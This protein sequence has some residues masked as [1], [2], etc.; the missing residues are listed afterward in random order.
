MTAFEVLPDLRA[1]IIETSDPRALTSIPSAFELTPGFVGM[2]H[3]ID[4]VIRLGMMGIQVP[5]PIEHYYDWPRDRVLYP[6][7]FDHQKVTAGF[8]T[9]NPRCY[10]LNGIGTMKTVTA[11]WAADY[12]LTA[13]LLRRVLVVAPIESLERA[14]GDTLFFHLTH[15]R[16]VILHGDAKRRKRLLEQDVDFYIINPDGLPVIKRE[17]LAKPDLDLFIIDELADFRNNTNAWKALDELIYPD[18]HPPVPWVWGLTGTP[19]PQAPTDAFH[20]CKLVTPTT[21]PRFLGEFR[22]LVMSHE[23]LYVWVPRK[24][25]TNVVYGV[26]RPAIRFQR[27]NC[28]DL[29]G[30]ICTP[31]DVEM[32]KEQTQHYQ[33]IQRELFT[34]IQGGKISAVN[35]GVK[36]SK[37]LQIACGCVYDTT[38]KPHEIDAGSRIEVL[39]HTIERVNEKVIVFVPFT[40]VTNI[41]VREVSKHWSCAVVYGDVPTKE[42]NQIFSDFQAKDDPSVLIAHPECMSRSLTLTEASTIIWYAPV[43]S[44][45]TY[46]Q[47]CGRITRQGQKYVANIVH[48]A[49]SAI[50]RKMYSRLKLRQK[51]Q[52]LLLDMIERGEDIL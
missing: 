37:L 46:E 31:L 1:L 5:N 13:G 33:E 32:S 43:D 28:L 17:L 12:L 41:L 38:G 45:Y 3:G 26:M 40:E 50:E 20:Q 6:T 30:E 2:P 23:S 9:A 39:L 42:R 51:T 10:C 4:E 47:A 24:E 52:G 8:L 48:L 44:N 15:R 22:A 18:N 7:V 49:G 35:E 25:S 27:D 21:V 19:I 14:W 11:L 29:P 36:R 34:E 16:F